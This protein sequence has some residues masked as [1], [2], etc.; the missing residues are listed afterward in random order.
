MKKITIE[1]SPRIVKAIDRIK[2]S[3]L[4]GVTDEEVCKMIINRK[5]EDFLLTGMFQKINQPFD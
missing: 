3:E 2:E 1:L 4:Y 5:V